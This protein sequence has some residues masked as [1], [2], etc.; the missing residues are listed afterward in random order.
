MK[1]KSAKKFDLIVIEL[2][3][4]VKSIKNDKEMENHLSL[5]PS[6]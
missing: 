5:F 1:K 6:R 4:D 2:N 3:N